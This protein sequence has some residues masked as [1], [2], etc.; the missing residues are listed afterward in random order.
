[1]N[2]ID[3]KL[4]RLLR[5]AALCKTDERIEMPFGFDTRVVA[6]WHGLDN[7][8]AAGMTW[9]LRRVALIAAVILVLT[10]AGMYQESAR[11]QES[12]EPF[13]NEFMIADSEIQL[14]FSP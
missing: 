12:S 5:S 14:E 11:S 7:T 10:A 3:P 9:L 8:E 2:D 6:R 4:E 1:M 13:A